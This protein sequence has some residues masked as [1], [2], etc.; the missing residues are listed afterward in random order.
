MA[1]RDLNDV[2]GL[3][4]AYR[5]DGLR[6]SDL[7]GEISA[8]VA[9]SE[10]PEAWLHVVSADA[11]AARAAELERL[12]CDLPL[13]GVPFAVKDNIDV[14]G[15]PTTA[16]C[17]AYSY[18][19]TRSAA[20]VEALLSA[21]GICIGKT[22]LDQFATGLVGTRHPNGPCRNAHHPDYISGGSSSGSAVVVAQGL[23]SF[24]LGTDTAGSGRVPAALNGIVGL[25]PTRGLWSLEGVVPACESMDCVSVF[26]ASAA[27]SSLVFDVLA[28]ATRNHRYCR[29]L[30][31]QRARR[32]TFRFGVPALSTLTDLTDEARALYTAALV[33]LEKRGGVRVEIDYSPFLEA[34]G[35]LYGGPWIAERYAAVGDFIATHAEDVHPVVRELILAS[36]G[37]EGP[38]VFEGMHRLEGLRS[39]TRQTWEAVDV[40]ALPT[41]SCL[42]RIDE[43]L[44]EPF[45]TNF[46]LG[47][48]HNF[49]NLLDLSACVVPA[50]EWA[51]GVPFGLTLCAPAFSDRM[52]LDLVARYRGGP[53]P[54]VTVSD[55]GRI[56]F[57]VV[58]AHLSGMPLN[59]DLVKAGGEFEAAV[60]TSA[61]YRLYALR[62]TVPPKPGLCRVDRD[63]VSIA[64]ELWSLPA[65]AFGRFVAAIP[66]PLG[67]GKLALSDGREESGFICEPSGIEGAEDISAFGGWK[68]WVN[69]R[70]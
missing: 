38:A 33:G 60:M 24:S 20:V 49:M 42:W 53:S 52:L 6:P 58:G 14:A 67:I 18:V 29:P 56:S 48:H 8:S 65:D 39:A 16:G 66:R 47:V 64:C 68:N 21:G 62:G 59:N 23:V 55:E 44:A 28:G 26:A 32:E 2:A 36:K 61:T 43:V 35:L 19:P 22:H 69:R 31:P 7:V 34:S 13:Y 27:T 4:T 17:P 50:G 3:L 54:A 30:E 51:A 41:L 15:M 9:A 11:L 40:L 25:K 45:K 10:R 63:G 12:S 1:Q 70:S 46:A 5:R 37:I 57:V